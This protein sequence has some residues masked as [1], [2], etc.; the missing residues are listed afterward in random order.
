M[1]S[2]ISIS[3]PVSTCVYAQ[4]QYVYS[5]VHQATC[6]VSYRYFDDMDLSMVAIVILSY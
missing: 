3:S 4:S 1:N 2:K 5:S 6:N